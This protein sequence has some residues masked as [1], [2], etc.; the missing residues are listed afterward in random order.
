MTRFRI[1]FRGPA[2]R[3]VLGYTFS[4]WRSQPLRLTLMIIGMLLATAADVLTP[5]YS[6][7]LVDALSLGGD[8][9]W[10][11]AVQALIVLL[12]L[13]A[14]ALITRQL[15]FYVITD[16]TLKIMSDMA[17]SSFRKLQR[18][19]TD[20]HANAFA[21][22]T[23]RKVSRAMWAM[24]LLNDTLI[25][26]LLPSLLMLVGSVALLAWYWPL[27]GVLVAIG[28][29]LFIVCTIVI[30]LGF[31]APAATLANSWDTRMGGALADAISCNA[32]VKAFG[33]EKREDARL[34]KVVTKWRSRTRRTWLIGTLNGFI[35]GA[36]LLIMRGVVIAFA[37]YLWSQGKATAGDITFVLT[38]FFMLQGYL[39]D[40]GMHIRNLQRSVNDMEELVQIEAEP[41]GIAD[42]PNAP[43]I[44]ISN[45][46]IR[47]DKV[48]FHYGNHEAALYRDF[49]VKIE[50][51]ERVGLV[52]HSGS[53]K[54][55][56]VKLIQRLYDVS[57]GAIKIDGQNI[58]HVTQA[59]LRSQI[60]IV[61]QE[62]ILF[63]RTLAENIAYAR[64]GA[65][66]AEVEEAARLAS[67]HD[68]ISRLPKGY[69]TLVGERGVKLSGGERQRVA[70]ARAFL[71]NAPILI[72]DEATSSLDSESEVLIQQA[73]ERLMIGRTTLVIAHRLSTVRA[74]DRLLV[75]DKGKVLEE[76]DHDALIRKPGG[77]YRRLFERQALELT[78]GLEDVLPE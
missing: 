26:A 20:W 15:T 33:A 42:K 25:I 9:A 36:N 51:G 68:F 2:F 19:S 44:Q 62:P 58:A 37:L 14:L 13:G 63:H 76:G 61:Q 23:V 7:R 32:V 67:A 6:G 5:L 28:S 35:Q 41:Y 49:S 64:P 65:T 73:M 59:S 1:N 70:I 56:F 24:D 72:L 17:A 54:T 18:F 40:V 50:A 75:F 46:E 66:Q 52:G 57:G 31:V 4:H 8:S 78:K 71:A 43:A 69:A 29:V 60:A 38:A 10:S 27:M 39:R 74:L 16:F 45:G 30:S 77:I 53:G 12:A 11:A 3:N 48:T 21:G 47:F 55:T 22:S 34:A